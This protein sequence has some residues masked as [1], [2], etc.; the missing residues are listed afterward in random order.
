MGKETQYEKTAMGKRLAQMRRTSGFKDAAALAVACD[1]NLV[2]RGTVVNI[3]LGRKTD[4]TVGELFALSEALKVTPF[5][6]LFDLDQPLLPADYQFIPASWKNY[7]VIELI[8]KFAGDSGG[9]EDLFSGSPVLAAARLAL[10][11][12]KRWLKLNSE[13]M[14]QEFLVV[15]LV[16]R[17]GVPK[18]LREYFESKRELNLPAWFTEEMESA[19][20]PEM[21]SDLMKRLQADLDAQ[22]SWTVDQ[23]VDSLRDELISQG[24]GR[25]AEL[26][27]SLS[28]CEIAVQGA[29]DQLRSAGVT[30]PWDT[31]ADSSAIES[32]VSDYKAGRTDG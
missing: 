9:T 12:R 1:P 14:A 16:E 30:I 17:R 2:T 31:D 3:E 4:V 23:W 21:K 13:L 25:I 20:T 28:L 15:T 6:I 27:A 22:R 32:A 10:S 26:R 8:D 5:A 11:E 24:Q 29:E 19:T 7:S 18:T